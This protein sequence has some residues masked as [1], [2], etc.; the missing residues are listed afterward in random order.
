MGYCTQDCVD[1]GDCDGNYCFNSVCYQNCAVD[2]CRAGYDCIDANEDGS[3]L[4]C[5]PNCTMNTECAAP[6]QCVTDEDDPALGLCAEDEKCDDTKDNDLDGIAD[7]PDSDCAA[8]TMCTQAIT[9]ACTAA[10]T[11]TAMQSGTNADG[12]SLFVGTCASLFGEFTT[13]LGKEDVY[14]IDTPQAGELHITSTATA[15]DH[16]LYVRKDCDD[17]TSQVACADNAFDPGEAEVVDLVVAAGDSYSIYVDAYDPGSEGAYDLDVVYEPAICNDGK[18]TLPEE[19]DDSNLIAGDGCDATCKV[20]DAFVC[21]NATPLVGGT[22][23]SGDTTMTSN[24]FQPTNMGALKDCY[25]A[26]GFG[27]EKVF[28]YTPVATGQVQIKV[29]AAT[30]HAIYTR[31]TCTDPMTEGVCEDGQNG[32][33]DEVVLSDVTLGTPLF[34]FVDAYGGAAQNGP[35]TVTVTP[36]VCG[37]GVQAGAEQCDDNNIL[38]GDG[39]DAMCKVETAFVCANAPVVMLGTTMGNN[40]T[41]TAVFNAPPDMAQCID[42]SGGGRESIYRYTPA[43]SG[44][45]TIT[46]NSIDKDMGIYVRTSCDMASSQIGCADEV[47][48][49]PMQTETLK[50]AV[51]AGVPITIFVDGFGANAS[52]G[53]FTLTLAQP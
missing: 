43:A 7:C 47:F 52:S 23:A 45:L 14:K 26:S 25:S 2:P 10:T 32:G 41:G 37:D 15:G 36:I 22:P 8:D 27:N 17:P 3:V 53:P 13:G 30:D 44:M 1:D 9:A 4:A 48:D 20:E 21:A 11:A 16:A 6:A 28:V 51:T 50:V 38:P 12:T 49:M 33:T 46:V 24:G 34:I 39:C 35:F 19:C 29:T 42:G 31:T 40:S 5:G 18:I